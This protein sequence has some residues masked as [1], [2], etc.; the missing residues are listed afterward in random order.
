MDHA[1][2]LMQI[3]LVYS[4]A[5]R[6]VE[7]RL[8]SLVAGSTLADAVRASGLFEG[9]PPEGLAFGIWGRR[10]HLSTALRDGDRVEIYRALTVDPKEARRMRYKSQP[11]RKQ[12]VKRPARAG[13]S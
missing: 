10:Q 12:K 8:L 3:E 7:T 5:A 13:R 1:E 11:A 2:G 6:T 4:P 9:P